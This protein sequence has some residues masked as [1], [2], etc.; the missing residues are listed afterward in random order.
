[1]FH[2]RS[3][4]L[5][6]EGILPSLAR[7]QARRHVF[8]G[9]SACRRL[10]KAECLPSK[11]LRQGACALS[12]VRRGRGRHRGGST[13][14]W[15]EGILPSLA[16]HQARRHLFARRS[17]YRRLGKAECLPSKGCA[18]ARLDGPSVGRGQG[19]DRRRGVRPSSGGKAFCLPW[20]A[21]RRADTCLQGKAPV[22]AWGRQNAFP[23]RD[24][25]RRACP[26]SGA[27]RTRPRGAF[28]T[29][30]WREGILPSLACR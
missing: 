9:K 30:L 18:P 16:R 20:R 19:D 24:S 14:L 23:P 3:T 29:G 7:H 6:R 1:M 2:T 5:W 13:I 28:E 8:A 22:G 25:G 17:A 4:G 11:G 10:G 21:I 12:R 27:E 15:R 26:Q